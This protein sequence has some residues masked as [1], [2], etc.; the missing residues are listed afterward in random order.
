MWVLKLGRSIA[1]T[2]FNNQQSVFLSFD[3][4]TA[5]EIAGIVQIS[6]EIVRFKINSAK[7]TVGSDYADNIE[8]VADT[9]NSY[10]KPE[11]LLE[12]WDQTSISIHGILPDDE[13][14]KNA[15]N[16]G[17]VWPEFQRWFWS[18]V[19]PS[20]T[21]VLVA[22]NGEACDLKWLWRLTQAPNARYSLPENIKFFID[23]YRVIEKYKSCGFNK[24]KSKIEAYELGVVWKYANNGTNLSGAHDSL[25]DVKAQTDILVHG[26]FVPFIDRSSSIQ[27]IDEIFSRTVQNEWHKELKPI[28]PVHAP[29]V[30]LTNEHGIAH[31]PMKK[32]KVTVEYKCGTRV[33][34]NKC[35]DVRVSLGMNSG[36]YCRMCYRKQL[37]TELS[38]KDR[39]QRCR[40]SRMGC[41]ICKE[42]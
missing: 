40:T 27:P 13:R 20:E 30:E 14:I 41:P 3:I 37:T 29:W 34:T 33:T 38:A 22:W 17:T 7:K 26:S 1:H 4:E 16:M 9:F 31:P 5:G 35:T 42:P 28:R 15:G 19:S 11:V 25:V 18:I 2:I 36:K 21:V 6:A 39:Q 10:V 32:T 12:Y 23:P 8:R 24:T